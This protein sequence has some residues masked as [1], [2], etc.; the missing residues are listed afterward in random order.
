MPFN[1]TEYDLQLIRNVK[2]NI[3]ATPTSGFN[4]SS[5]IPV[6]FPP[7]ITSD[8]KDSNWRVNGQITFGAE[9]LVTLPSFNARK[10]SLKLVYAVT[11][12]TANGVTWD[13]R[14]VADTVK[15]IRGYFYNDRLKLE[16]GAVLPIIEVA[17]FDHLPESDGLITF[18]GISMSEK[19]SDSYI[20]MDGQTYSTFTEVDITMEMIT[21]LVKETTG[22]Y[23]FSF[24]KD[25]P[26]SRWY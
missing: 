17:L 19:P 1:L 15:D 21:N 9:P 26:P 24:L 18:R 6:Q 13:V 14:R 8:S 11:G 16:N 4:I 25:K 2:I 23:N 10:V 22:M 5:D 12:H 7:Y 3:R 20:T